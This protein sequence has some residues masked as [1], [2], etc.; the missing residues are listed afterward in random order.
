MRRLAIGVMST[1][2]LTLASSSAALAG[3]SPTL[4]A[5]DTDT[6]TDTATA[7]GRKSVTTLEIALPDK[8]RLPPP[9][10]AVTPPTP[11]LSPTLSTIWSPAAADPLANRFIVLAAF[12]GAF[13]TI[14]GVGT[15]GMAIQP[16]LQRTFDRFELQTDLLLV[17]WTPRSNGGG[18]VLRLGAAARYQAARLRVSD[19]TLDAVVEAGAGWQ[20]LMPDEGVVRN[21][22][23]IEVGIGL[24]MLSRIL[25]NHDS[26][27]A[28]ARPIFFGIEAMVRLLVTPQRNAPTDVACVLAFGLPLGR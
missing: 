5:S 28:R 9:P 10:V 27:S 22:A 1:V 26:S 12:G 18:H 14:D 13:M 11:V 2:W 3:E 19:L 17:D 15:N 6:G 20:R 7:T 8:P 21:R 24:R 23:D 16:T 25:P 4:L